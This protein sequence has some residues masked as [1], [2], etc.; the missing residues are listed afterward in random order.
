LRILKY[1]GIDQ[2]SPAEQPVAFLKENLLYLPRE[3]LQLFSPVLTAKER[4][5]VP[6]LRNRRAKYS[7]SAPLGLSWRVA[8]NTWPLL[9]EGRGRLGI[10]EGQ[11]ERAWTREH[12]LGGESKPYVGRLDV[13]LGDYEEEREAERVRGLRRERAEREAARPEE[14]EE[15]DSDEEE[16]AKLSLEEPPTD[17]QMKQDFERLIKERFIYGL[18]EG[19]DYDSVDWDDR[20][21]QH[22]LDAEEER[23]F[24]E[25]EEG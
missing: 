14:D 10:Q 19:A 18:L 12:F 20:W 7:Q 16:V 2:P 6:A 21:D 1:L 17:E 22:N 4:T 11:E 15:T 9:W 8:K 24:D 13:L 5:V 3:L 25:E 23:W